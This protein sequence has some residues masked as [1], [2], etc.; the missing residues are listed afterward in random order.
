MKK[1]FLS[2]AFLTAGLAVN[3]QSSTL[4]AQSLYDVNQDDHVTV[5]D[6]TTVV[7][8]VG[9]ATPTD[10]TVVDT[11]SFL[12]V[13]N[14]LNDKLAE[15]SL[16]KE[17]IKSLKK[18]LMTVQKELKIDIAP[19]VEHEYVDLGLPSGT[20]WATCNVGAENPEDAGLYFAWGETTGYT[21]DTSDG[22]FFDWANYKWMQ[23]GKSDW[24]YVTKYTCE[25][26]KTSASWYYNDTYVGSS[27]DG[28]V[29]KNLTELLP[30]DDAATAN[31]GSDWCMPTMTQQDE[32]CNTSYCTWTWDSTKK[33]YTVT[34][35]KNG[36]SLFL[37]AA[38]GRDVGG[39]DGVCSWGICWSR[40]LGSSYS[41]FACYLFFFSGGVYRDDYLR[42][43]GF[44]VRPVLS[45]VASE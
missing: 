5:S 13:L 29:Y 15:L 8:K 41:N 9:E 25:D 12:K 45:A 36:N 39:L 4:N 19:R 38:G 3:A 1:S 27:V 6:V 17:Q 10:K 11:E 23:E 24:K 22:R 44:S 40:S 43:Y 26:G 18:Q 16:L 7:K 21:S 35:K 37:P 30:E 42:F 34:S 28:K 2:L 32:L 33:G 14:S 31:W 20:L